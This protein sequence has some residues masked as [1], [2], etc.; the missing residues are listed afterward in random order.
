MTQMYYCSTADKLPEA[1]EILTVLVFA[2]MCWVFLYYILSI[3]MC[4]SQ[5]L[6]SA[7]FPPVLLFV[8]AIFMLSFNQFLSFIDA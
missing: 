3:I 8:S 6:L 2:K 4:F 7:A 1:E 5:I